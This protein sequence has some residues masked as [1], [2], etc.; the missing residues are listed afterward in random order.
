MLKNN[1]YRFKY[2]PP[3]LRLGSLL[4]N[5]WAWLRACWPCSA[6]CCW[7]RSLARVP[8]LLMVRYDAGI[9]AA[10]GPALCDATR[11]DSDGG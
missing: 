5:L 8:T 2:T 10:L 6:P 3:I 4:V 1:Q 11:L 7:L 9:D